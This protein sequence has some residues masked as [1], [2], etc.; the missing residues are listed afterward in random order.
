MSQGD[1]TTKFSLEKLYSLVLVIT[2]YACTPLKY[3]IQVFKIYKSG[4]HASNYFIKLLNEIFRESPV[5]IA[6]A[7]EGAVKSSMALF[8]FA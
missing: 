6:R 3:T 1:F 4:Y 2:K 7:T 5:C 8:C